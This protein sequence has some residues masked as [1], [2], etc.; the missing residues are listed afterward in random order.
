MTTINWLQLNKE[1]V[2]IQW[3][4]WKHTFYTRV[5]WRWWSSAKN[6]KGRQLPRTKTTVHE[7]KQM[8]TNETKCA[9]MVASTR[10]QMWVMMIWGNAPCLKSIHLLQ[11][12]L[13]FFFFCLLAVQWSK[14]HCHGQRPHHQLVATTYIDIFINYHEW[15]EMKFHSFTALVSF[16]V[17]ANTASF[18]PEYALF[19]VSFL[20][21]DLKC[22][23]IHL[24]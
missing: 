10:E 6:Y 7:E 17:S 4:W 14:Q 18:C 22:H 21:S 24:W 16:E 5:A 9:W 1:I 12:L 20:S 13:A 19:L 3:K 23:F 15:N 8:P 2:S 11:A